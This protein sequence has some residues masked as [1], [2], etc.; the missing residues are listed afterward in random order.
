MPQLLSLCVALLIGGCAAFS[1][2]GTSRRAG[3]TLP[4]CRGRAGSV[5]LADG[6]NDV[7]NAFA[8]AFAR[9]KKPKPGEGAPEKADVRGLGIRRGGTTRDGSL[10][11][12]R[13]AWNTIKTLSN[14]K[15]WQAEEFG[16]IGV[17]LSFVF[18]TLFFYN[19]YVADKQP[20]ALKDSQAV[21]A[22][23]T[24]LAEC[25]NQE[26][27]D[28]VTAEKEPAVIKERKLDDCMD[29]AFSNSERNICK[30]KFGGA[31]TPFGF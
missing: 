17:L 22:L 23:Q 4:S 3:G 15:D 21:I 9:S 2:V 14:P 28:R 30:S 19:T 5:Q 1:P 18:A 31:M 29:R 16:F 24:A 8:A 25:T 13:A 11:D 12:V 10:G 27:L 6:D 7:N 20:V 26:C